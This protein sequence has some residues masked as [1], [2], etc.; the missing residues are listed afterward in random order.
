MS[1]LERLNAFAKSPLLR[2]VE[3]LVLI[4]VFLTLLLAPTGLDAWLAQKVYQ[5]QSNWAWWMRQYAPW[6]AY[7]ASFAALFFLLLPPLR[8]RWPRGRQLAAVWLVTIVVGGGVLN[9]VIM[10]EVVERPRPRESV[11]VE[12]TGTPAVLKGHGFPSGH[13]TAGFIFAVPFF[14]WRRQKPRLAYTFLLAGLAGGAFV[15]Y[16]RMVAGAHFAS[17][18]LWAGTLVLVTALLTAAAYRGQRDIPTWLTAG[19]LLFA[20]L[21]L[22]LF[23]KFQLQLSWRGETLG[24]VNLPCRN[25]EVVTGS[26]PQVTVDLTGYGAPLSTLTLYE[27]EGT[28]QLQRWRGLYHSLACKVRLTVPPH[29]Q[30]KINP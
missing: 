26:T 4:S 17:D 20:L 15:G 16:A 12:D 9:Q 23:N 10:Q 8:R 1:I 2:E 3:I 11:L 13:A 30:V 24:A 28:V 14:I 22:I 5:P 19:L 29:I 6:P 21:C 18:V 27:Q 25:F 7:G